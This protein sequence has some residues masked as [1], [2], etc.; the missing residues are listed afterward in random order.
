[1]LW[2]ERGGGKGQPTTA[3][4]GGRRLYF[5][6]SESGPIVPLVLLLPLGPSGV[7]GSR[8]TVS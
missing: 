2:A 1:M 4:L 5:A 8:I 7:A 3:F 6:V